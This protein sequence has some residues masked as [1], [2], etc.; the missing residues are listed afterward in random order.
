MTKDEIFEER[1]KYRANIPSMHNGAY[2]KVYAKAINDRS[3]RAAV[4][5]KCLDCMCWQAKEVKNCTV[6][7]CPCWEVRPY[8]KHPKNPNRVRKVNRAPDTT[9]IEA[10]AAPA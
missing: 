9:A 8:A 3:L 7:A 5:A 10:T 4:K 2:A 1:R 6:A